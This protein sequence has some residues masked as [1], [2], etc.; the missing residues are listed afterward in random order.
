MFLR[1]YL[2]PNIENISLNTCTHINSAG[3]SCFDQF[4]LYQIAILYKMHENV[5]DYF[6]QINVF[7]LYDLSF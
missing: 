7:V 2:H 1:Q 3:F 5:V 6:F 4:S